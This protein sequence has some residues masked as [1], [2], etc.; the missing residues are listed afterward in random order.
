M[1]DRD[2]VIYR[3]DGPDWLGTRDTCP[4]GA[5]RCEARTKRGT[6]CRAAARRGCL[7]CGVHGGDPIADAIRAA[8]TR[9]G[10]R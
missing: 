3:P 5:L 8:Y 7:T 9:E 10:I 6:R 2:L 4:G 1:E